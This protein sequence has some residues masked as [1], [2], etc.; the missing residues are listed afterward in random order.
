METAMYRPAMRLELKAE[1][2]RLC[3]IAHG[4][5]GSLIRQPPAT[6]EQIGRVESLTGIVFDGDLRGL[7]D[8]SNGGEYPQTWFAAETDELTPFRFLTLDEVLEYAESDSHYNPHIDNSDVPWDPRHQRYDWHSLWLP[9]AVFN[10]GGSK[11]YFDAD[12][13]PEGRFGQI[14]SYQHDPDAVRYTAGG[15]VE[16]LQ[17]SNNILEEEGERWLAP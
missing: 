10:N 17:E 16:F 3:A 8:F 12:P 13:T 9:F 4:F 15:L 5:G 6:T 7:Y 2:D 11:L 14:I 1:L